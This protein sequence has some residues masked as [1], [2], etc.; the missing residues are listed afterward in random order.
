MSGLY[1]SRQRK[2][3]YAQREAAGENLWTREFPSEVRNKILYA[4]EVA[5]HKSSDKSRIFETAHWQ[6]L[7]E[8]GWG[9]LAGSPL[10]GP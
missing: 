9:H 2:H 8:T 5:C 1:C 10:R 7:Q 6:I 4:T 3:E